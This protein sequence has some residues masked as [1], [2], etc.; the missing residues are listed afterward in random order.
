LVDATAELRKVLR[1]D[2]GVDG[3]QQRALGCRP[4][5]DVRRYSVGGQATRL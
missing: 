4:I 5:R 1:D 3:V 2:H